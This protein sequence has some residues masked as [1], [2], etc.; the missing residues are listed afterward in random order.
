MY[1]LSPS[2]LDADF[3]TLGEQIA[4]IERA[5]GNW[6]HLDVMDGMFVPSISFGF[7]VIKSIRRH[8]KSFLDVHLMVER[9]ERY[10]EKFADAGAD[11]IV[12]HEEACED[13]YGAIEKIRACNKRVGLALNPDT[14]AATLED[15][16]DFI[17]HILV[18]TVYPGF[19]GQKYIE[20]STEKIR[21]IKEMVLKSKRK[22]DIAVD[23]GINDD[24]LLEVLHAGANIITAGSAIIKGNIYENTKKYINA[25]AN[26]EKESASQHDKPSA[27]R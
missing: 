24:T 26:F 23:G 12:I 6:L 9:P 21:K 20:A 15:K 13:V 27:A 1:H 11:L 19:G 18:M 14:D 16:L 3:Y 2:V 17:D 8:A 4:A 7:P 22:I 5:G 25:I 10:I